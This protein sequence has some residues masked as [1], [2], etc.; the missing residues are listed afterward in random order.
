[1]SVHDAAARIQLKLENLAALDWPP[2]RIELL[3]YSDGSS[4]G[5]DAIVRR[6]AAKDSRI[7]LVA[8]PV[9]RGK[10]AALN[11]LAELATGQVLLLTDV[12]PLLDRGAVRELVDTLSDPAVACASGNLVL[13]GSAGS[14]AYW[15][16]EKL[17]R[18]SEA[19]AGGMVGVTGAVYAIRRRDFPK[20]PEDVIL[21]DMWVPLVVALRT[22]RRIALT[23]QARAY[24]EAF[25]DDREF[26]R[27]VRTLAGNYQLVQ[28][29]PVLLD[30]AANPL[31]FEIV[32]HKLLRLACPWALL[33]LLAA[34]GAA[35]ATSHTTA[36]GLALGSLFVGQLA[37][38]LL[39]A[40]GPRG[41]RLP[42]LARSFVVLNAAAVVGL[43][44]FARGAQ[45]V[46]W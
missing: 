3:I 2:D 20:L 23:E 44:R 31:W 13:D 6:H 32:S 5:T 1:M 42:R 18:S 40:I 14:S 16:Y 19:R 12:R 45:K 17:I 34:S 43:W 39:A 22:R 10:P 46:T 33:V 8:A 28:K 4:D 36:Q 11:R 25:E 24:D 29:L 21:D 35:A 41:G 38:Y 30:P 7:R 26:E 37:F 9:R 27:K 15:R